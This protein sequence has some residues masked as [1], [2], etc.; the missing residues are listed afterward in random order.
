M[1]K[2]AIKLIVNSLGWLEISN[3]FEI[4]MN[5]LLLPENI[6]EDKRFEDIAIDVKSRGKAVRTIKDILNKLEAI[7]SEQKMKKG[8]FV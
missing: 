2:E 6:D 1:D 4:E 5:K 8:P 3:F 7:G